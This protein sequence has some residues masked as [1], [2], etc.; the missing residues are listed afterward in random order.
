MAKLTKMTTITP[1]FAEMLRQANVRTTGALIKY[2]GTPEGRR[3]IAKQ[4]GLDV[5]SITR[6]VCHIDLFRVTGVGAEYAELL[7][8]TG[9][10]T[11]QDLARQDTEHVY[12]TLA[13]VNREKGLVKKL[14]T[15]YQVNEWIRQARRMPPLVGL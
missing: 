14:P 4:T 8:Q 7:E 1:E 15:R 6:W 5:R 2:G 13:Q 10:R 3:E 11:V 12:R 9:I